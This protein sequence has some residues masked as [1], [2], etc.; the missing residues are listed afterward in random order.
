M[1]SE[2]IQKIA[3]M[4]QVSIEKA[5]ELYPLIR[6]QYVV[7][8]IFDFI[9]T[10]LIALLVLG[11]IFGGTYFFVKVQDVYLEDDEDKETIVFKL[12]FKSFIKA[13]LA[14]GVLIVIMY[15]LRTVL[16]P[17]ISFIRDILK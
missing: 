11:T 5:T 2:V 10:V 6:T 3:D 14:L 13:V 9:G 17:D 7:Y 12:H 8:T 1:N 4:F 15:V 16:A